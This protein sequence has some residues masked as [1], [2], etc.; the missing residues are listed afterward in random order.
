MK[1]MYKKGE[2]WIKVSSN[3]MIWISLCFLS[4]HEELDFDEV[5]LSATEQGLI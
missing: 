5:V 3:H 1:L 2:R 4:F